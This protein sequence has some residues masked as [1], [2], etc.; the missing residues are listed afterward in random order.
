MHFSEFDLSAKDGSDRG[1][2]SAGDETTK[3]TKNTK[4]ES[5]K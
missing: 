3:A 2:G 1:S 5:G 4:Q